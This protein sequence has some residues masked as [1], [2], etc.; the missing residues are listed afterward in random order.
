MKTGYSAIPHPRRSEGT[1]E[2]RPA[3]RPALFISEPTEGRERPAGATQIGKPSPMGR[4]EQE[5]LY[6][7]FLMDWR[8]SRASRV[9]DRCAVEGRGHQE[10][11][12][13]NFRPE[14]AAIYASAFRNNLL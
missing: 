10:G 12:L 13:L 4:A 11:Q 1:R 5:L 6:G 9:P 7:H 3:A 14:P 8:S 2:L